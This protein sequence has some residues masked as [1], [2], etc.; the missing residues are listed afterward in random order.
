MANSL[1]TPDTSSY[2]GDAGSNAA[3]EVIWDS[4]PVDVKPPVRI[5]LLTGEGALF[6]GEFPGKIVNGGVI[7]LESGLFQL[8]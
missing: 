3:D 2:C 4:R 7:L 8:D 1:T 6:V 5:Y